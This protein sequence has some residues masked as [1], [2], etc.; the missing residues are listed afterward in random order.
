MHRFL[1]NIFNM[2]VKE[3]RS[4]IADPVLM[5]LLLYSFT[6]AVYEVAS[7]SRMEVVDAAIA[8]ADEDHS[9]LSRRIIDAFLPP[10]FKPAV[11]LSAAE[12][13]NVLEA[14]E[15]VFVL[16][17]PPGFERDMLAGRKPQI[18]V[19]VDA[20]AMSM[21][22]NGLVYVEDIVLREISF[23]LAQTVEVER[24]PVDLMVRAAFNPN[25]DSA[26]FMAVMQ[27][28]EN[29]N[30]LAIILTGAALIR[31][32]EHGT[33]EHLLAMPVR[34]AEI[35]LSKIVAN[36]AAILLG[37]ILSIFVIVRGV[38]GIPIIGS[39]GLFSLG[40]ALYL[41]AM[42]ALG[43]MVAT[44]ARTMPQ[45]GLLSIPIFIVMSLLS[46]SLTPRESMPEWLQG[47]M[48]ISPSTH[49]VRFT[50]AVLYRDAGLTLVWPELLGIC[51]TGGLF[52]VVALS[53]FRRSLAEI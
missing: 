28:I 34:P 16:N 43:I 25:L 20:T 52:F 18:Q 23:Y 44:L 13:D 12:I 33:I 2:A 15:F 41:F 46:G 17:I 9:Q 45:L 38:L 37:A 53:R 7:N 39:V 19:N 42:T 14:G 4:L 35:M 36:G 11:E 29:I 49:F 3:L 26:W 8:I 27:L 32:R 6:F 31:E 47:A 22:G 48:M 50:Q 24:P 30:I 5:L 1:G 10:Y 21:A 40:L 51:I